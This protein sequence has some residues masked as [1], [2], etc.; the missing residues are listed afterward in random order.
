MSEIEYN[1]DNKVRDDWALALMTRG[2]II[3]LTVSRWRAQVKLDFNKLG[4]KFVDQN[5]MDFMSK[6]VNLGTHKLLPP[7]EL[8]YM[9]TIERKARNNLR[10]Y[11]FDTLWGRFVP[12]TAFDEWKTNNDKIYEDFKQ[13][14]LSFI[15]RYDSII[16]VVKEDYRNMAKDVWARLYPE[17]KYGATDSF[18]S[19]FVEEVIAKI[20]SKEEILNTFKYEM[21]YISIPMP[22]VIENNIAEAQKIKREAEMEAFKFN[23]EKETQEKIANEYIKRKE[24][25]IGGFLEATVTSMRRYVGE[26]CDSVLTSIRNQSRSEHISR[27]HI[28]KIN[29]MID[30][31]KLLN[32]YG[33]DEI[34]KL[35]DELSNEANKFK[36]QINN[37]VVLAKLSQ[38]VEVGSKEFIPNFNPS[39]S[40][41]EIQ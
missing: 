31:V 36:D 30:K 15:N 40:C 18:M 7:E 37:G 13:C 4:L 14:A 33:D 20:P 23:I 27:H 19:N 21:V 26:L 17:D 2:L 1:I 10:N 5:S 16:D 29:T 6:Y 11:S 32:F 8:T 25:L 41:L 28:R 34:T 38:I 35:L 12:M 3:K 9:E 39:I 22:S 24:E